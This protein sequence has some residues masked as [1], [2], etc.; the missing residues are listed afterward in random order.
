LHSRIGAV[1]TVLYGKPESLGPTWPG[2][3]TLCGTDEFEHLNLSN[4]LDDSDV[5]EISCVACEQAP[6]LLP[7]I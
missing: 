7:G 3:G 1:A 6:I 4:L 2:T 5:S